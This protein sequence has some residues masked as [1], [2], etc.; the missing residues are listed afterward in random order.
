MSH[1]AARLLT[2]HTHTTAHAH[3]LRF[4]E[5]GDQPPFDD[6]LLD[7]PL[8]NAINCPET[9]RNTT[10]VLPI[11]WEDAKGECVPRQLQVALC[12]L[13]QAAPRCQMESRF[14]FEVLAKTGGSIDQAFLNLPGVRCSIHDPTFHPLTT[15]FGAAHR[16]ERRTRCRPYARSAYRYLGEHGKTLAQFKQHLSNHDKGF[17]QLLRDECTGGLAK[18]YDPF[19]ELHQDQFEFREGCVLR[20]NDWEHPSGQN[21]SPGPYPY[22]QEDWRKVGVTPRLV[23]EVCKLTG[24]PCYV[25]HV[26]TMVHAEVPPDWTYEDRRPIVV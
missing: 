2:A 25:F 12:W 14:S 21:T 10:H 16:E 3:I 11:A 4:V 23:F 17:T 13:N 18:R 5:C 26:S 20:R 7:R 22:E 19:F 9:C 6:T 1:S 15:A 8:G 24:H